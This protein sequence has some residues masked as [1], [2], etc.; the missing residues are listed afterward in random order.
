MCSHSH[1][2]ASPRTSVE[3][4]HG[5]GTGCHMSIHECLESLQVGPFIP[6]II[7]IKLSTANLEQ[8]DWSRVCRKRCLHFDKFPEPGNYLDYFLCNRF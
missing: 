8:F 1:N 5:R 6:V 3:H 4:I 7:P 2:D